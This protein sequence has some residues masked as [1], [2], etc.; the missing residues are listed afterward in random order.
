MRPPPAVSLVCEDGGRW[1]L[2]E[3][4]IAG[5]T[6]AVLTRWALP[7]GSMPSAV[8]WVLAVSAG[9]VVGILAWWL[10]PSAEGR[11]SWDGATTWHFDGAASSATAVTGRLSVLIDLGGWLLLRF[12][13]YDTG[14]VRWLAVGADA[15]GVARP[16]L[17]SAAGRFDP[18]GPDAGPPA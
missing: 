16:A 6:A 11:L 9:A 10:A 7:M 14:P 13:P 8:P 1:R 4:G 15:A 18:P 17:Y 3:S 12:T 5:L 2:I